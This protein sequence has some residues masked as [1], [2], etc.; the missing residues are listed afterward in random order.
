MIS[1]E[2]RIDALVNSVGVGLDGQ[3]KFEGFWVLRAADGEP[4]PTVVNALGTIVDG[5]PDLIG[6]PL[7]EAARTVFQGAGSVSRVDQ[8]LTPAELRFVKEHAARL[9]WRK[10]WHDPDFTARQIVDDAWRAGIDIQF[11]QHLVESWLAL[12]SKA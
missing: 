2:A 12:E 5:P 9:G 4:T 1:K 7:R 8:C 6:L 3:T 11:K 10:D